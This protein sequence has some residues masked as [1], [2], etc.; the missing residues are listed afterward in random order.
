MDINPRHI[1][2]PVRDNLS[3]HAVIIRRLLAPDLLQ[4]HRT[5]SRLPRKVRVHARV[6][7]KPYPIEQW[8]R[9]TQVVPV[10]LEG[11]GEDPP[12][13]HGEACT[14][15]ERARERMRRIP[16]QNHPVVPSCQP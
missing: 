2:A 9:K 13:L 4:P 1:L 6:V 16:N 7:R 3:P 15:P 8:E 12:I 10:V 11:P 5:E 14:G